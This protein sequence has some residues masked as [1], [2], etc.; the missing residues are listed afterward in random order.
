MRWI[1]RQTVAPRFGD[2]GNQVLTLDQNAVIGAHPVLANL[3]VATG[4]SGHGAQQGPAAGRAIA[5][6]IFVRVDEKPKDEWYAVHHGYEIQILD[7]QDEYGEDSFQAFIGAEAIR[8]LLLEGA[9]ERWSASERAS[10]CA[11][12]CGA[13]SENTSTIP[14]GR[15]RIAPSICTRCR[16]ISSAS[17]SGWARAW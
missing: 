13:R 16:P 6:L 4:F 7:A 1:G 14:T 9:E 11:R 3:Y 5:E 17:G 12:Y 8:K 10:S 2:G 15:R